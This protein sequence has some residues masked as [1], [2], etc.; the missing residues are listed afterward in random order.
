MY[1]IQDKTTVYTWNSYPSLDTVHIA[2]AFLILTNFSPKY[3]CLISKLF[4]DTLM[5]AR[6]NDN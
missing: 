4:N 3:L 5:V 6:M 1:Y 2:Q